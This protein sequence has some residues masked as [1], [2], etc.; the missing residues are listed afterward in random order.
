MSGLG[1]ELGIVNILF[2]A[3]I[4][5]KLFVIPWYQARKVTDNPGHRIETQRMT[6]NN[7][8]VPGASRI[9]R[10]NRDDITKICT[11]VKNLRDEIKQANQTNERDHENFWKRLNE[12][13]DKI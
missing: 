1:T 11:N 7:I 10:E 2:L 13:R 9:C 3:G 5:F 4:V 12:I 8:R 6:A